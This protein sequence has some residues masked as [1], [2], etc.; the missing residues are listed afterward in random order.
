MTVCLYD[1]STFVFHSLSFTI[2]LGSPFTFSWCHISPSVAIL[3]CQFYICPSL[4]LLAMWMSFFVRLLLSNHFNLNWELGVQNGMSETE[5]YLS[6]SSNLPQYFTRSL[7]VTPKKPNCSH[8]S[9]CITTPSMLE[10]YKTVPNTS[11]T[12]NLLEALRKRTCII[13]Q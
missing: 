6:A 3:Q 12:L 10:R 13:F 4:H 7:H 5:P 2:S 9:A 8:P 1:L 11:S